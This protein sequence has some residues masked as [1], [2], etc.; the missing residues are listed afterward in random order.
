MERRPIG[1]TTALSV[2]AF[3][4]AGVVGVGIAILV[5]VAINGASSGA[6]IS[7]SV[8]LLIVA[9]FAASAIHRLQVPWIWPLLG[10]AAGFAGLYVWLILAFRDFGD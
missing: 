7:G 9:L 10:V 6:L 5:I 3:V 4:F 1:V 2:L 8:A